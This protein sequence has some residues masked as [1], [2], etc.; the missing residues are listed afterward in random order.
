MTPSLRELYQR[1]ILEHHARPQNHGPLPGCTHE[2]TK[3]NPLCGDQVTL[4]LRMDGGR[5]VEARF[6]GEGCALSRASASLLTLAVTDRTA[7]EAGSL[8]AELDRLLARGTE[9]EAADRARLGDLVALE[10]V[11][12]VPAR[13]RCA[14]LPFEALRAAL[15][16]PAG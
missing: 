7:E 9:G 11:R 4:R 16:R 5:I 15:E 6:E 2:A 8:A 3:H 12:D 10:G 13:R 14:T 1:T